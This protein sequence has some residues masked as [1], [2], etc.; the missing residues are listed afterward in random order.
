MKY[1]IMCGGNYRS[2][3]TPKQL[4]KIH[5]EP[6]LERTMRLLRRNGVK[7]IYISTNNPIFFRYGNILKHENRFIVED[8]EVKEGMWVDC[9][10]PTAEPV[11]YLMGDVVYSE[12]AI[13]KIVE[14]PTDDILFFASSPPF[15]D[16]FTKESAEPY[17]FKVVNQS[18]FRACI[19]KVRE[20]YTMGIFR[21]HPIA[22]ELWQVIKDTP[23]N[24][25]EYKNYIPINDFT[26]DIDYP[27]DI[28][29][30]ESKIKIKL[31]VIIPLYNQEELVKK[32]LDSIPEREDI[33]IIVID[34]CSTDNSVKT[35]EDYRNSCGKKI[36][37]LRNERNRGVG[38]T[39]NRGFDTARGEYVLQLDSDGDY[40]VG[41]EN[42]M[43]YLDGSDLVYYGL[44]AGGQFWI[45]REGCENHLCG[46]VKFMRREF[47]GDMREPELENCEDLE[48]YEMLKAKNPRQRYIPKEAMYLHYNY[49]RK[50][51]LT[52]NVEHGITQRGLK[53]E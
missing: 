19:D 22:W 16:D 44:E 43:N 4:M 17:A 14:T 1:I 52:W 45:I 30:I 15:S 29:K 8:G 13:K 25:I 26:C 48:F 32:G 31:S 20:L 50:G 33:E 12:N 24:V 49:P 2:F 28:A 41:L 39:V 9:F 7:D 40:L 38:Y 6:V 10:Y 47:I 34:D 36:I 18:R 3:E 27:E 5:N 37:I 51:S 46:T 35:V 11:T 42:G 23:L 53:R 21:R